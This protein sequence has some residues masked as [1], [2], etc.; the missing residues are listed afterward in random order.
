MGGEVV[1]AVAELLSQHVGPAMETSHAAAGARVSHRGQ[2]FAPCGDGTC[3]S[4]EARG[5]R[6]D[7][8]EKR[9]GEASN[10]Q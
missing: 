9:C 1:M 8:A 4:N 10:A 7:S 2:V 5:E 6:R 3:E